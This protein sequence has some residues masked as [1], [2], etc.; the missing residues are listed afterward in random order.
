[1]T[2]TQ[3]RAGAEGAESLFPWRPCTVAA[4][5]PPQQQQRQRQRWQRQQQQR[6]GSDMS[7]DGVSGDTSG[8]GVRSAAGAR[9]ARG[10]GGSSAA[11][12]APRGDD[13]PRSATIGSAASV[14][15][16]REHGGLGGLGSAVA[17]SVMLRDDVRAALAK[18]ERARAAGEPA[19]AARQLARLLRWYDTRLVKYAA[20]ADRDPRR[21]R[22]ACGGGAGR[23][24]DCQPVESKPLEPRGD[25]RGACGGVALESKP[26]GSRDDRRCFRRAWGAVGGRVSGCRRERPDRSAP[27]WA[28]RSRSRTIDLRRR[29]RR[30]RVVRQSL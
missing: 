25:G 18:I 17:A 14:A 21:R 22:R 3:A 1:M 20:T 23:A 6:G 9:L 5:Y 8:E 11:S 12:L 15:S 7:C 28:R 30:R 4:G 16:H 10:D 27:L 19:R 29:R 13:D 24:A 2:A 26:L